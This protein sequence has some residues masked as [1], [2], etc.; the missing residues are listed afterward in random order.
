M[1]TIL[2]NLG[3]SAITAVIEHEPALAQELNDWL[4]S[5]L[6]RLAA[7]EIP[8]AVPIGTAPVTTPVAS[9]TVLPAPPAA[10]LT[11]AAVVAPPVPPAPPAAVVAT[12]PPATSVTP[13]PPVAPT[14]AAAVSPAPQ[15]HV[16]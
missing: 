9:L 5:E 4:L 8:K 1:N 2:L 15:L 6:S 11:Q 16:E 3:K 14:P 13:N 12:I 7:Y 10:P